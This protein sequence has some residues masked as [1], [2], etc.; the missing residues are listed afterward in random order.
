MI[1]SPYYS[2]YKVLSPRYWLVKDQPKENYSYEE[3][4]FH[5]A[6]HDYITTLATVLR[7]FEE[8]IADGQSTPEM[9]VLYFKKIKEL[10]ADLLYLNKYYMIVPKDKTEIK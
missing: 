9:R 7:F 2:T 6:K 8:M 3:V 5:V 4:R 10:I 1:A